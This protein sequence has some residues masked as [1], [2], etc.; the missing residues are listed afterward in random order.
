MSE[1]Q[2]PNPT[3]PAVGAPEGSATLLD[4]LAARY[5]TAARTTLRRMVAEGRVR[6]D[7]RPARRASD[8]VD[9]AEVVTVDERSA[10]ARAPAAKPLAARVR[11][12]EVVDE[13]EDLLVVHKPAGLLTSTV[14]GERR[15]T[16]LA[17]VKAAYADDPRVRVGLIHRL[18]RD[19]SGLLVFSKSDVAFK[20]LKTQFF[21]HTV[22]RVYLALVQGKPGPL[23]GTID[24]HLIERADG[25]VRPAR[26]DEHAKGQRAVT[27][28]ET[29]S[30]KAG[31]SL[32]R[33]RLLTGRKHQIRAHFAA[34]KVPIV[35][36]PAY[37]GPEAPRLMLA[38]V[39]LAL[40]HPRTGQR[41]TWTFPPP[42]E[43]QVL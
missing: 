39:E 36:D 10:A 5:P 22:D 31:Q 33:A 4:R 25:V 30:S 13:D 9:A 2:K 29:V 3:E 21:H 35:G 12:L 18:D 27:T 43:M 42:P 24:S 14:P 26:E 16:A 11:P 41:V 40:D 20:S 32:V 19:A 23:S 37:G 7:G 34:R 6:V 8:R 38:N 28:Y 15:R 1:P 17:L